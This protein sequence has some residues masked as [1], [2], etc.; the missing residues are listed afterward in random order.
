VGKTRYS[1]SPYTVKN[2]SVFGTCK[3][4]S[5]VYNRIHRY[6]EVQNSNYT[7]IVP[8]NLNF[9]IELFVLPR[10]SLFNVALRC[11]VVTILNA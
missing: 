2:L 10:L 1:T 9:H 5:L 7:V 3:C 8:F 11:T 4:S 6:D